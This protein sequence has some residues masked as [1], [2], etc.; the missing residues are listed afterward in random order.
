[1]KTLRLVENGKGNF[2][3]RSFGVSY[4]GVDG[5]SPFRVVLESLDNKISIELTCVTIGQFFT[6]LDLRG[7]DFTSD[8]YSS[9][10]FIKIST[11]SSDDTIAMIT[12]KAVAETFFSSQKHGNVKN[13]SR[14]KI[15]ILAPKGKISVF[16]PIS[17][18]HLK[19]A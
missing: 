1:M 6:K 12:T 10:D 14:V 9:T 18:S 19:A 7:K 8:S 2:D 17:N 5:K 16:D 13:K 15:I 3:I 11:N 4:T